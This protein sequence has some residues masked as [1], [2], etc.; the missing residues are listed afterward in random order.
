LSVRTF[1]L[2]GRCV[3]VDPVRAV[4]EVIL[5][6]SSRAVPNATGVSPPAVDLRKGRTDT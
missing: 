2:C 3:H 5:H 4:P 1:E 6:A